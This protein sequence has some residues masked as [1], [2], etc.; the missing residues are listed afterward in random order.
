M[1]NQAQG[2]SRI[3]CLSLQCA[4]E[5]KIVACIESAIWPGK[6]IVRQAGFA[7]YLFRLET[8]VFQK[9]SPANIKRRK[10]GY[11]PLLNFRTGILIRV[12]DDSITFQCGRRH[13]KGAIFGVK[14]ARYGNLALNPT[15]VRCLF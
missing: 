5:T 3:V 8:C 4:P 12:S 7:Q 14:R 13:S 9:R 15:N 6:E 10:C 11:V 2:K 1:F